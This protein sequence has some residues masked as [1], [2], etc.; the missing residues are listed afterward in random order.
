MTS[1]AAAPAIVTRYLLPQ[2]PFNFLSDER[3]R[4][5][6]HTKHRFVLDYTWDVPLWQKSRWMGNWQVSGIFV[7]QSGQPF[8]VFAG[9]I[10]GQVTQRAILQGPVSVSEDP[11][12]ALDPSSFALPLVGCIN[13]IIL[14]P[15][16][17]SPLQPTPGEAGTYQRSQRLQRPQL[18]QL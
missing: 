8:T 18:L 9:P 13:Q 10:L 6:F 11:N 12:A 1:T 4:S 7:G 15:G 3:G 17:V 14:V 16:I 5:D 2:D